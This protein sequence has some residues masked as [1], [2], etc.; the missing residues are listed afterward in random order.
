MSFDLYVQS[1][2]H[3]VSKHKLILKTNQFTLFFY[4]NN[5]IRKKALVLVK[6]TEEQAKNKARLAV[7]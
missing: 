6:K 2:L 3:H 1:T 7:P 4:K 5:Y